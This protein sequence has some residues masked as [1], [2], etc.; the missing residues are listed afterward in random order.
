MT[1]EG[2][3]FVTLVECDAPSTW[4]PFFH[5]HDAARD[6]LGNHIVIERVGRRHT[7]GGLKCPFKSI[8]YRDIAGRHLSFPLERSAGDRG[9]APSIGQGELL[10]GTMRA[11]LGN[12]I[13]TPRADWLGFSE[14]IGFIQKSEFIRVKPKDGLVYFWWA[15]LGSAGFLRELPQGSGGTRPR[16]QEESFLRTPVA[17]PTLPERKAIHADL[18]KCAIEEWS[19]WTRKMKVIAGAGL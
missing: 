14:P 3:T 1:R 2:T 10:F 9:P 17:I 7:G 16:L 11:Y 15:Y 8:A 13:V 19:L 18:E 12:V 4:D 6:S 5:R